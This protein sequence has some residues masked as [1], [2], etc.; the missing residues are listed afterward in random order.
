MTLASNPEQRWK[1]CSSLVIICLLVEAIEFPLGNLMSDGEESNPTLSQL[2]LFYKL[3]RDVPIELN[4]RR[5][6]VG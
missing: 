4:L 6:Y 2:G 1:K 3:S 5:R